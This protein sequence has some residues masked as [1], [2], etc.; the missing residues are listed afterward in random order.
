MKYRRSRLIYLVSLIVALTFA[1]VAALDRQTEDVIAEMPFT[2]AEELVYEG[3]FSKSL[4]RGMDIAELRFSASLKPNDQIN[5]GRTRTSLRLEV[6]AVSKGLLRKLF[7]IDFRQRIES[8]VEPAS[9]TV[10]QT[11]K[12]D[13]QGRRQRTSQTIYDRD[14]GK[15]IWVERDPNDPARPPRVVESSFNGAVQDIASVF[16]FLRTRPL[17]TGN[18]FELYVSDSGQVYQVPV[19]VHQAKRMR[20]VL[21]EVSTICVEPEVFGEGRLLRGKGQMTIWFTDDA[22]RIPVR[23]QINNDFG[24]LDI[25]LK[26]FSNGTLTKMNN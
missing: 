12:L 24:K 19:R 17:E 22:R 14:A 3:E 7:G 21:G 15:V 25:K 4:L 10:L 8:T 26:S 9:F 20:T 6:E 13:E 23:A 18:S 2:P 16:Y 5:D 1:S 11:T